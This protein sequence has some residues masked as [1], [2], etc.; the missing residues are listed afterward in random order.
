MGAVCNR[1]N[2]KKRVQI[3]CWLLATFPIRALAPVMKHSESAI[4]SDNT[5]G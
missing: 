4:H 5:R 2:V 3:A 1:L